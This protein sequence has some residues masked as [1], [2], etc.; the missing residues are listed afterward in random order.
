MKDLECFDNHCAGSTRLCEL[1]QSRNVFK[2]FDE[3]LHPILR[4]LDISQIFRLSDISQIPDTQIP[5][6][7]WVSGRYLGI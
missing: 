7:I 6:G 4:F 5:G 1:S 3:W 2:P